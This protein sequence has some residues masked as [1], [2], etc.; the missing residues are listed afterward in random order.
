MLFCMDPAARSRRPFDRRR[1][2]SAREDR[3]LTQEELAAA[4]GVAVRTISGIEA[5]ETKPRRATVAVLAMALG[6][7]TDSLAPAL[8]QAA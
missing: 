2:R 1:L 5:G 8:T 4:A 7:P 3:G 6:V